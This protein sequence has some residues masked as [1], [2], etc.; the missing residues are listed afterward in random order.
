MMARLVTLTALATTLLL[1]GTNTLVSAAAVR[2]GSRALSFEGMSAAIEAEVAAMTLSKSEAYLTVDS[3]EDRLGRHRARHFVR[4]IEKHSGLAVHDLAEVYHLQMRREIEAKHRRHRRAA[5]LE[6]GASAAVLMDGDK[7]KACCDCAKSKAKGSYYKKAD[8]KMYSCKTDKKLMTSIG[9]TKLKNADCKMECEAAGGAVPAPTT[10]AKKPTATTPK[11]GS[12]ASSE[13]TETSGA[14]AGGDGYTAGTGTLSDKEAKSEA[15]KEA[16]AAK[17]E[18]DAML[19]SDS[20]KQDTVTADNKDYDLA[21][22]DSFATAKTGSWNIVKDEVKHTRGTLKKMGK[23]MTK[24]A[25]KSGKLMTGA[26]DKAAKAAKPPKGMAARLTEKIYAFGDW[27]L[28]TVQAIKDAVLGA[29]GAGIKVMAKFISYLKNFDFKGAAASAA[30]GALDWGAGIISMILGTQCSTETKPE[31]YFCPASDPFGDL[32]TERPEGAPTGDAPWCVCRPV[33]GGATHYWYPMGTRVMKPHAEPHEDVIKL[34]M[35]LQDKTEDECKSQYKEQLEKLGKSCFHKFNRRV[36]KFKVLIPLMKELMD[37]AQDHATKLRERQEIAFLA[38]QPT[39]EQMD[40]SQEAQVALA[41]VKERIVR[42]VTNKDVVNGKFETCNYGSVLGSFARIAMAGGEVLDKIVPDITILGISGGFM[43][44]VAGLEYVVDHI[45]YE[46]SI[47]RF[48]GVSTGAIGGMSAGFYLGW[49]WKGLVRTSSIE[50][51][52]KGWFQGIEP[53]GSVPPFSFFGDFSFGAY[54][55]AKPVTV[56]SD[57]DDRKNVVLYPAP[58]EI[59]TM[60]L[61]M[62]AGVGISQS[63]P[64]SVSMVQTFYEYLGGRCTPQTSMPWFTFVKTLTWDM[65]KTYNPGLIAGGMF[66]AVIGI[67]KRIVRGKR[68]YLHA[69]CSP[70]GTYEGGMA[71]NIMREA[72]NKHVIPRPGSMPGEINEALS[73]LETF[74]RIVRVPDYL[75]DETQEGNLYSKFHQVLKQFA[76]GNDDFKET[77]PETGVVDAETPQDEIRNSAGSFLVEAEAEKRREAAWVKELKKYSKM[78]VDARAQLVKDI[79]AGIPALDS[80]NK[81]RWNEVFHTGKDSRMARQVQLSARCKR[82]PGTVQEQPEAE[83]AASQEE[84]AEPCVADEE[85]DES[86]KVRQ[87]G[88]S[89][90]LK[91]YKYGKDGRNGCWWTRI[92]PATY[93]QNKP[94]GGA[95][96]QAW[97]EAHAALRDFLILANRQVELDTYE[98]ERWRQSFEQ[99][100]DRQRATVYNLMAFKFPFKAE[101]LRSAA[102]ALVPEK[103]VN[104]LA[105]VV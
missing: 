87:D 46:S 21:L 57:G 27:M 86:C 23:A 67:I 20:F 65:L 72:L 70:H 64:V 3:L 5:L 4:H 31:E 30:S 32:T 35:A 24:L 29:F 91:Y 13:A 83:A 89:A 9:G 50:E 62:S 1:A 77:C 18:M 61:G 69:Q 75:A 55:T 73:D 10:E 14:T 53:S 17:A 33:T 15:A 88:E 81:A 6:V 94:V 76:G 56:I 39:K 48:A 47:F 90:S 45:T 68:T 79:K 7:L 63:L 82:K 16:K 98:I 25:D 59:S 95:V 42:L 8:K 52:Y 66:N 43:G 103:T 41:L 22:R 84:T 28:A 60:A 104:D 2:G 49:G 11:G 97:Q 85:C 99:G 12:T 44:T 78:L 71:E 93:L 80:K 19:K 92:D 26:G 51:A 36:I 105:T 100:Y 54:C 102:L 58:Q 38:K 101:Q 37:E 74:E 96:V 40:D 34:C